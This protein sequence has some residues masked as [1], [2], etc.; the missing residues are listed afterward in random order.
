M[1]ILA[2]IVI[3]VLALLFFCFQKRNAWISRED[4][5]REKKKL[6]P[7]FSEKDLEE[8]IAFLKKYKGGYVKRQSGKIIYQDFTGKEKGD[9][10]GIFWNLVFPNHNI[11]V[12]NKENFRNFLNTIGVKGLE[13]RPQYEIRDSR[14]VN[15]KQGEE[16]VRKEVGNIGEKI[17]RDS[18]A[19]LETEGYLVINGP[20]LEYDGVLKEYDHIVIGK[21]GLF[22]I[23]TKAFGMTDGK[24]TKASLFV[25]QGDKWFVRKNKI[26]RELVSPTE[27]IISEKNHLENIIKDS[28]MIGVY[29]ILVLSNSEI[30]IKNNI[31][32]PY[33]L[34]RV[35]ELCDCIKSKNEESISEVDMQMIA[36]SI[37]KCRKN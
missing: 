33:D 13:K 11:E 19:E 12:K 27:Q 14:L 35:D 37:D 3:I 20:M 21:N 18:L 2:I 36:M 30:F 10:K 26:N 17:V 7:N 8:F 5:E 1:Y 24:S 15:H 23:E 25:D 22:C 32:L 34:V 28:Y 4:F 29:P 9:L 16:Y 6:K 31:E